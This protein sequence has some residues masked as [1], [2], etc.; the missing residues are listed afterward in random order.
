M[1][2][3]TFTAFA[4][5]VRFRTVD[6]DDEPEIYATCRIFSAN[7]SINPAQVGLTDSLG[8]YRAD[9]PAAGEYTL[10]IEAAGTS[11]PTS[12]RFAVSDEEPSANLGTII[13]GGENEELG[14]ITVTAQRPLVVKQIDRIGYDIQADP[15]S[16]TSSLQEML[17]RVPMVAVDADG[18]ITVNG[19]SNFKIYKN[20]RPNNAMSNN[21][22]DILSAIPASMIKS[23]EVITE[24]GARYDA[25][26]VG[27]ILN[28]V[29]V[30]NASITGVT[31]TANIGTSTNR[32]VPQ[33][34]LFLTAQIDK[35]TFSI[36]GS[37][38][39][40]RARDN[41]NTITSDYLY[42]DGSE[43][44]STGESTTS[45]VFGWFGGEASWDINKRN[46]VT[47]EFNCFTYGTNANTATSESLLGADGSVLSSF[48]SSQ[49]APHGR[50]LNFDG[51]LN[52]Q[53][54]TSRAGETLTGSYMVSTMHQNSET[55][56]V[57]S[58]IVGNA[59]PY[60]ASNLLSKLNFIEH[61]FQFDWTRPFGNIHTLEAGAKY[62]LRRNH[63]ND[64]LDYV[65][66][67][68]TY[69][70][71][72]HITDI[73]AVYGQYTARLGK[74]SLRGGLRYEFSKL[75]ATFPDGSQD[76]FS[77][78]L[79]DL[80]PSASVS[81]QIGESN[82]LSANYAARIN[83]PGF[84]YLNPAVNYSPSTES[85]G[86]P[87]LSSAY[88]NSLKLSY[89]FIKRKVNFN[90]TA[91]YSFTN[92]NISSV[93]FV[94]PGTG[95]V[96]STYD[97]IGRMRDL[98]FSGFVQWSPGDKTQ[99]MFNGGVTRNS[100]RQSGL[101]LAKWT[102]NGFLRLSQQIP[103]KITLEGFLFMNT[104]SAS[105]VY[106]YGG[107]DQA[108]TFWNIGVRRSFL[109]DRLTVNVSAQC[110][111]GKSVRNYRTE[112]VNGDYRGATNY[113]IYN[114]KG[115]S[116]RISYRFGSLN[117]YVKKTAASINNDDLMGGKSS[118]AGSATG[119]GIQ[120]N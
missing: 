37:V 54:T 80:V 6:A 10:R 65:G 18:N 5:D 36:N 67:T 27:A 3:A 34:S 7:D 102:G 24:P 81:W 78:N 11:L 86:N 33:G 41:R 14:G 51:T 9:L 19:S 79:N 69:S 101:R 107:L 89:M 57:Y 32:P 47:A 72:K 112:I 70:D 60:T 22:K 16:K 88:N 99:V 82:T 83:R 98:S 59:F 90:L 55:E 46:L 26:G 40:G 76:D 105:D 17:R 31:G 93:Q 44:H 75:K 68:D 62:I 15:A 115:V 48:S 97:N 73:G 58:D 85:Y 109:N 8:V 52:Y 100:Y 114:I 28:I 84:S 119:T 35:V 38:G 45:S 116:F 21:A 43:R 13:L 20:G 87:D 53:H 108:G 117:A 42:A 104:K 25:E 49:K 2:L 111:I 66:W 61:T 95:V 1:A 4:Y 64:H 110:P 106:T 30:E 56:T 91:S 94:E 29:T 120:G 74:V 23:V 12:R 96:V 77:S 92:D 118:G 113:G 39:G 103:W 71:F 63:S 50:Y